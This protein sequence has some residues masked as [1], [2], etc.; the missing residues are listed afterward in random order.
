[1]APEPQA[2]SGPDE[3]MEATAAAHVRDNEPLEADGESHAED[4][5]AAQED[6]QQELCRE[7][8]E[9]KGTLL[10]KAQA[11]D[12][13]VQ[14]NQQL[15]EQVA[16]ASEPVVTVDDS[17]T[18]VR[19]GSFERRLRRVCALP[20][21]VRAQSNAAALAAPP[22]WWFAVGIGESLDGGFIAL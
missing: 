6:R 9:L 11:F 1:M 7:L 13:L 14:E 2:A 22:G 8:E 3:G 16:R 20:T 15:K 18:Q 17:D 5:H 12:Q 10:Q 21:D 19:S 4:T